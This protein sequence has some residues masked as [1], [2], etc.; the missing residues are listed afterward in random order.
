MNS[1]F[2]YILIGL[3][4]I[5]AG[6]F[7][8]YFSTI[9]AYIVFASFLTLI[10]RPL[11]LLLGRIKILKYHIPVAIRALLTLLLLWFLVIS[12]FRVFIPIVVIEAS[13]LANIDVDSFVNR[14]KLPI[15]SIE[16]FLRD[17]NIS[18]NNMSFEEYLEEK[19][20]TLFD[21]SILSGFFSSVASLLG[22]I[23]VAIF[24]ISFISFFLLKEENLLTEAIVVIIPENAEEHF[25]RA[26]LSVKHL[27]SRYLIGI[28]LQ[29]TGILI[30][31]TI[32]ML[33]VGLSFRQ[34]LLI[35][36]VAAMLNVIPYL[37]PLIGTT[38]GVILGLAFNIHLEINSL[39]IFG[40]YMLIVFL[41]VQLIDNLIFQPVI[42]S[43]SVRAH[44]LEIFLV[45]LMA[46]SMAG[47]PGMILGIP[48]YTIIRVFAKE[49]FNNFRV[50]KKMTRKI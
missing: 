16:D 29:L 49:F 7:L 47:V 1:T 15:Q 35:G 20:S 32:G 41:I 4:V 3:A 42:F 27:L 17:L 10:G 28:L 23:F 34:S 40:G 11:V 21:F 48:A 24:S 44:P 50:V 31:I 43:Q 33:I 12:F 9:V 36:L 19:L 25:R 39:L 30:L 8:W 26:I 22:N 18:Q 5:I 37:G 13:Q 45:I 46:G 2:R 38:L 14:L 6:F